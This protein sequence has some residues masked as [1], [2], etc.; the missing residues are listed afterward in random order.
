M[1]SHTG[2]GTVTRCTR[3]N[4]QH[5]STLCMRDAKLANTRLHCI[6]PMYSLQIKSLRLL[7]VE[8]R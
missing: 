5:N 7:R 4:L 8:L 2:K 1:R 6:L 3:C